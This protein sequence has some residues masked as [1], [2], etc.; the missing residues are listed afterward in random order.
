MVPAAAF[1]ASW[2]PVHAPNPCSL[3]NHKSYHVFRLRILFHSCHETTM[4]APKS[5]SYFTIYFKLY[6]LNVTHYITRSKCNKL[7]LHML[8]SFI[9]LSHF[10]TSTKLYLTFILRFK[11]CCLS[12]I[13]KIELIE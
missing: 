7:S 4:S 12:T 9:Y 8:I 2:S 6:N 13:F 11:G 3:F 1:T 10:K 5:H